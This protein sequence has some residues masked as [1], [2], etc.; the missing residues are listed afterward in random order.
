MAIARTAIAST[1][2]D[3]TSTAG[4]YLMQAQSSGPVFVYV[5]ASSPTNLA[6]S[7]R[8]ELDDREFVTLIVPDGENLYC[9]GD[10]GGFLAYLSA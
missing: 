9:S 6:T 5:A 3:V 7:P 2:S 4:T 1:A 10:H 8:F